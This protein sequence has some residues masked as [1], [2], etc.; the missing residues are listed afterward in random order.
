ML[1]HTFLDNHTR[2]RKSN[3]NAQHN[4][5]PSLMIKI[6]PM[7]SLGHVIRNAANDWEIIW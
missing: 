2:E 7:Q 1:V 3:T 4:V 6:V 5:G